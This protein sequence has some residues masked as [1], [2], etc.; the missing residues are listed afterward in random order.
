MRA[1]TIP[2]LADASN[3]VALT[4]TEIAALSDDDLLAARHQPG[5]TERS[6]SL[7]ASA[8]KQRG[9][10]EDRIAAWQPPAEHLSVPSNLGVVRNVARYL[11]KQNVFSALSV[12]LV[13]L[14]GLVVGALV[15]SLITRSVAPLVVGIFPLLL[16]FDS[17]RRRDSTTQSI[18]SCLAIAPV[19][20]EGNDGGAENG[21]P[22][23]S[24]SYWACLYAFR[25]VL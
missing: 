23:T 13:I 3:K 19:R 11:R 20:R 22:Q 2:A 9:I 8:L 18:G 12:L 24:W 6:K 7:C 14:A 16:F 25:Q 15:L 4:Q 17:E 21:R 10:P 1:W 5:H